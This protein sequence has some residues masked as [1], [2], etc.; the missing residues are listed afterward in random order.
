MELS[1]LEKELAVAILNKADGEDM[2]ELLDRSYFKTR[3]TRSLVLE[4]SDTDLK[5]ILEERETIN[6]GVYVTESDIEFSANELGSQT[7]GYHFKCYDGYAIGDN[8]VL[9]IKVIYPKLAEIGEV[10]KEECMSFRYGRLEFG[11]N[12]HFGDIMLY[13]G[14]LESFKVL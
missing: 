14:K 7:S 5:Y 1:T 2:D 9:E 12:I 10:F 11:Y 8:R 3:L 4:A 13:K 6:R